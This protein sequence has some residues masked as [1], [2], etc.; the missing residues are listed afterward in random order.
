MMIVQETSQIQE[1]NKYRVICI[2]STKPNEILRKFPAL[3]SLN[4]FLELGLYNDAQE[5][6]VIFPGKKNQK[7]T[8][9]LPKELDNTTALEL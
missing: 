7:T 4:S 5:N 8:Q 1:R 6:V 3:R 9:R 2:F